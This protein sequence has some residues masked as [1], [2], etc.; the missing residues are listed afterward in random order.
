[1]VDLSDFKRG[2]IIG[3]CMAGASVTKTAQLF[4]VARSTVSKVMT[5]F[6]KERKTSSLKKAKAVW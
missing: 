4:G 1:M 6:E 2:E 3:A 5:A